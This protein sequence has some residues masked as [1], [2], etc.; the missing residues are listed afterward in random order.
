MIAWSRLEVRRPAHK[1]VA[2]DWMSPALH[3]LRQWDGRKVRA[4]RRGKGSGP[5]VPRCGKELSSARAEAKEANISEGSL[6]GGPSRKPIPLLAKRWSK[7]SLKRSPPVPAR[8]CSRSPVKIWR[9]ARA[10]QVARMVKPA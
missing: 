3:G 4:D 5:E 8:V 7:D 1:S 9:H 6:G 10:R 2:R